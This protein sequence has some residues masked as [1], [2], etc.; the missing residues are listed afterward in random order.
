MDT[1][2]M[3]I[4]SSNKQNS[5]IKSDDDAKW[6]RE[7]LFDNSSNWNFLSG[8]MT[9]NEKRESIYQQQRQQQQ[10][11]KENFFLYRR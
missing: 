6:N 11:R 5:R 2:A 3:C 4:R 7:Y 8:S 9:E 10:Q 1:C